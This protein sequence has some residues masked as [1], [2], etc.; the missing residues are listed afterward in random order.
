M[1]M[2]KKCDLCGGLYEYYSKSELKKGEVFNGIEFVWINTNGESYTGFDVKHKDNCR[3]DL[4]PRCKDRLIGFMD[5][6]RKESGIY[7]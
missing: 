4:C 1:A 6:I 7:D 5:T 2:A 3:L